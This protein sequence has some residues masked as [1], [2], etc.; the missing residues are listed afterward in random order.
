M[1]WKGSCIFLV[2]KISA[3]YREHFRA[4]ELS[5]SHVREVAVIAHEELVDDY[6]LAA[7]SVGGLHLV[8]LKRSVSFLG[9]QN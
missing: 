5:T 7:Y 8:T 3:W 1:F 9:K 6:P 4:F 2:R